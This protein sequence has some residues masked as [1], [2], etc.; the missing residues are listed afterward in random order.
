M[1]HIN[2]NAGMARTHIQTPTQKECMSESDKIKKKEPH[3]KQIKHTYTHVLTATE[4][5]Y[6]LFK[7]KRIFGVCTSIDSRSCV[8]L[9]KQLYRNVMLWYIKKDAT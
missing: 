3:L 5:G 4:T 8:R 7:K 2:F 9:Q 6:H 1:D